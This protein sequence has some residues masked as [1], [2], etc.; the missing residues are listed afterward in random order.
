M[1]LIG[2]MKAMPVPGTSIF[3]SRCMADFTE[4]Q[5]DRVTTEKMTAFSVFSRP[6]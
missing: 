1:L 2:T 6:K 4:R 5:V 3:S